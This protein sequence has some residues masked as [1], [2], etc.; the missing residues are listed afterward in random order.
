MTAA[1]AKSGLRLAPLCQPLLQPKQSTAVGAMVAHWA[2]VEAE[3]AQ[4][5]LF[6]ILLTHSEAYEAL[7]CLQ[8]KC[9]LSEAKS[10]Y[11]VS[12]QAVKL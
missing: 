10:I 7:R 4:E 12:R 1:N 9:R 2:T 5:V 8:N 11:A 3:L 6:I